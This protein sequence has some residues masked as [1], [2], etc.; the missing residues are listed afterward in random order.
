[1]HTYTHVC[2]DKLYDTKTDIFGYSNQDLA[3]KTSYRPTEYIF[4]TLKS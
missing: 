3:I 4:G 2:T 1:M